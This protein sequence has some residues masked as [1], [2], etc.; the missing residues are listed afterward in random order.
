MRRGFTLIETLVA[1]VLVQFG[2][3]AVA[4]ASGIAARDVAAATR[5]ARARDAARE[6]I[7][8][9][10]VT[11]CGSTSEGTHAAPGLTEHWSVRGDTLRVIRDSVEYP[12][13]RG[14]RG[15]LVLEQVA[16]CG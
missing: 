6:R 16:W 15:H 9:L 10:R 4:A 1:L 5:A 14:R 3:L 13:P 7:E 11:A 2:L 12:L 8:A